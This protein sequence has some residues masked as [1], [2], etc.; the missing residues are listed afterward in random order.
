MNEYAGDIGRTSFST[1]PT[2][3]PDGTYVMQFDSSGSGDHIGSN[4]GSGLANYPTRPSTFRYN[5]YAQDNNAV[6]QWLVGDGDAE[7]ASNNDS[8]MNSSYG[9]RFDFDTG[10]GPRIAKFDSSGNG[11][12]LAKT[13]TAL[14]QNEWLEFEV[15]YGSS[16]TLEFRGFDSSGNQDFSLSASDSDFTSGNMQL[17]YDG[18]S[19][20]ANTMYNDYWRII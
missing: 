1:S 18:T 5:W 17:R 15:V 10:T 11:T 13:T 16:G 7:T 8:G 14:G 4:E 19:S 9:F 3:V 2:P 20:T 12:V 6:I